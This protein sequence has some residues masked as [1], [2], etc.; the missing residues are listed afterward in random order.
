MKIKALIT[1]TFLFASLVANAYAAAP[2]PTQTENSQINQLKNKIASQVAQL[3]LV[4][5]RGIVGT[6][7]NVA[8]SNNQITL[9][10][11]FDDVPTDFEVLGHVLDGHHR[12][13]LQSIALKGLGVRPARI[14]KGDRDLP[15]HPTLS[16]LDTRDSQGQKHGLPPH[17]HRSETPRGLPTPNHV[18][19]VA[20][21][22]TV[23]LS[24][25]LHREGHRTP[26]IVGLHVPIAAHSESMIQ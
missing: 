10:D 18:R 16:A 6:I 14:G 26:R 17:R 13:E 24:A 11:V 15:H 20:F 1:V 22:A 21:R 8:I 12:R 25:L 9:L 4:E 5:K 3:K 23:C 7:Q 19:R 2:S